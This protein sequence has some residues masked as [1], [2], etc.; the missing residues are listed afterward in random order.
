MVVLGAGPAWSLDDLVSSQIWAR[1]LKWGG[2]GTLP[3][4]EDPLGTGVHRRLGPR[5]CSPAP[6]RRLAAAGTRMTCA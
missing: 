1:R 2:P 4:G 3:G 5:R 6:L